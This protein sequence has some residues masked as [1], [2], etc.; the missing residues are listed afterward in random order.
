M[1][2]TILFGL[3]LFAEGGEPKQPAP[4]GLF[5]DPWMLFII[6]GTFFL[7]WFVVLRPSQK[8]ERE[9]RAQLATLKK[10]DEVVAAGGIIGTV[11]AIKEKAGGVAGNED[12]ITIRVDD[13][14]RLNV[15]RSSIY[16]VL[17]ADE[18]AKEQP[19]GTS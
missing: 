16:K 10:N 6:G 11:V 19:A 12:V 5:G 8:Q 18:A 2:A 3:T 7:F 9:R 15:L 14:T 4:G 13:K 1:L 17:K